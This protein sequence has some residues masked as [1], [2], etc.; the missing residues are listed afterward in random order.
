[1]YQR[2]L[3]NEGIREFLFRCD[4]ELAEEVRRDGCPHCSGRLHQSNYPRKPRG[5]DFDS[6]PVLYHYPDARNPLDASKLTAH[7]RASL[8]RYRHPDPLRLMV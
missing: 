4:R 3:G 1:L 6:G 8:G 2:L 5:D 7:V